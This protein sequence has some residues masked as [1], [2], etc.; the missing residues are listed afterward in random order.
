M[1]Y[2][3]GGGWVSRSLKTTF[4]WVLTGEVLCGK[5]FERILGKPQL[6]QLS[7]ECYI[8]EEVYGEYGMDEWELINAMQECDWRRKT[9][10]GISS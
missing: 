8:G 3:G 6:I 7:D 2:V 5:D 1:M 4:S 10:G 9:R